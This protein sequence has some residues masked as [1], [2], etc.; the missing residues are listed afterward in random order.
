MHGMRM[1]IIQRC[2]RLRVTR[3]CTSTASLSNRAQS[4]PSI[5]YQL[6]H[7]KTFSR[8]CWRTAIERTNIGTVIDATAGRGSDTIT[9]GHLVGAHGIVYAMDVQA[10]AVEETQ[11]R[12]A[13]E[14]AK[15]GCKMGELR[16]SQ[17]SHESLDFLGL[18]ERSVS[19]V[20]YNL[21]WYPSREA[22]R[23]IV[24]VGSSTVA[25]LRSAEELVAV[26][27]IIFVTAYVGHA[28]GKQEEEEVRKWVEELSIK[29]WNVVKVNYP[30]R[31]S[32]PVMLVCERIA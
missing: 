20:V 13:E 30:S 11:T 25:S 7:G 24:T 16:L 31:A 32:A 19:C 2:P 10:A 15:A 21:G 26:D 9:L 1:P 27:G 29:R 18:G 8:E 28:G 12:Y 5:L 17:A 23:S 22:D 6:R 14:A 3:M 4:P